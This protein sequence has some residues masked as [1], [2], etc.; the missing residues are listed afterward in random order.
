MV[1]SLKIHGLIAFRAAGTVVL[2]GENAFDVA[3]Y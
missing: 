1:D 2:K 3:L